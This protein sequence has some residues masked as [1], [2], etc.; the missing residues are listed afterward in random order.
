MAKAVK[1]AL[2]YLPELDTLD[3]WI[4]DSEKEREAVPIGDNVI[5]KLD[6][7]GRPIG[8]EILSLEKLGIDDVKKLPEELRKALLDALKK[9]SQGLVQ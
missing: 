2:Y 9:L 6:E 3:L 5:V 8:V 7:Q 1:V 4:D